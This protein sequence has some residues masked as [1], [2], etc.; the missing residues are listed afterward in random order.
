MGKKIYDTV[1]CVDLRCFNNEA[2]DYGVKDYIEL[3]GFIPGKICFL[4]F[5]P[6][7]LMEFEQVDERE[8]DPMCIGQNGTPCAQKWTLKQLHGLINEIKNNHIQVLIGV[9]ANT[10]S[11]VWKNT[12][13]HWEWNE[14]LQKTRDDKLLWGNS[15]NILK[16]FKDGRYFE[17]VLIEKLMQVIEAFG[18]Q[19]YVAGDG[20]LGL[21]GPR[22]TL[23]DTD[24]SKDMV[25]QFTDY[26]GLER[27]MISDYN[28]RADYIVEHLYDLW[29]KFWVWRWSVHVSKLSS[30]LIPKKL[31]F[32]AIDA[33]SRNPES[34]IVNFG[35]NYRILYQLGLEGVFVQARETNKWRKHR[36]GEYVREQNSIYTFLSHKA[37]EPGLKYY[38]AQAT[39]NIPEFWNTIQDLPNV[40]E[41]ETYGYLWTHCVCENEWH[42]VCE[43][44]CI[45]WGN[46]LTHEN[47]K[48]LT[49]RWSRAWSLSEDYLHPLGFTLLWTDAGINSLM[50]N[51][52]SS[53]DDEHGH[54]FAALL[55]EG[56]CIQS[57]ISAAC[58]EMSGEGLDELLSGRYIITMDSNIVFNFPLLKERTFIIKKD[59][60]I[61]KDMLYT[62]V[63]GVKLLKMLGG[64]TVTSGRILGFE[65]K[66]HQY[67]ISVENP[68]NLFYEQ[69]YMA[70]D[71]T[72]RRVCA[73]PPREWFALPH[74]TDGGST[75]VS[76]PPD[77]SV[78]M[79]IEI[80]LNTVQKLEFKRKKLGI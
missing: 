1:I 56:I 42:R 61:W 29:V 59:G 73:L 11:P 35:I 49:E 24:F 15:I 62:W 4:N 39:V 74:S 38:W 80:E 57:S 54:L 7:F 78:Q 43:G 26:A 36:E 68:D 65:N 34:L 52:G 60:I 66:K 17:D 14:I 53:Y 19:G 23:C 64:A 58:C 30:R 50:N 70:I 37:F 77:G 71:R 32:L 22:E 2:D 48:W 31:T 79:L 51:E 16:R 9:L 41:R 63:E 8:M 75:V 27:I 47:W 40:A 46:D 44:I 33:W 55:D 72:I 3:L 6:M 67:V 20:M 12:N 10:I 69:I 25:D 18:F 45:I 21:R 28:L 76:I 13:Y 5:Q